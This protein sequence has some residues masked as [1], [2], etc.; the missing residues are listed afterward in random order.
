MKKLTLI[1]ALAL[2]CL[3]AGAQSVPSTVWYA[4]TN[5]NATLATNAFKITPVSTPQ[6]DGHVTVTGLPKV[7]YTTNGVATNLLFGGIYQL[8]ILGVQYPAPILFAVNS[9]DP[10][11]YNVLDLKISGL[12]SYVTVQRPF[13]A[14]GANTT[15]VTNGLLLTISSTGG[16]SGGGLIGSGSPQ[17][18][19]S[20][21]PP[22]QYYDLPG[23]GFY[24]KTNGVN[25]TTGWSLYLV[26]H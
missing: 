14:A 13:I 6:A 18:V 4:L 2:T 1:I 16:G 20:A 25:T 3:V 7:I 11:T 26:I 23:G 10:A 9:N 12:N 17:N 8:D 21:S 24:I 22:T 15:V 19:V 5:F